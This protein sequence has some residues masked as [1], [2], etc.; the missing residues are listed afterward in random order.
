MKKNLYTP[1]GPLLLATIALTACGGTTPA[2]TASQPP[3]TSSQPPASTS[4]TQTQPL[5]GTLSISAAFALYPMMTV[6]ADKFQKLHPDT[7]FDIQAGGAGKRMTDALAGAPDI[8][9]VSREIRPVETANGAFWV[10]V[11]RDAVF[12]IVSA[13]NPSA[14][15]ITAK[16]ITPDA[17]KKIFITGEYKTW[18]QVFGN[19][20]LTA[21]IHL[22]TRSDSA[23]AADICAQ[24]C[25]VKAQ[26]DIITRAS[27]INS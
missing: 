3:S 27:G 1:F 14:A 12:P 16:A 24:F 6:W 5:S 23:G 18:G 10:S 7:Q 2:P 21:A 13:Q 8:G 26:A 15:M 4:G 25:G 20:A 11:A 19:P 17:F 9:M 22:Y